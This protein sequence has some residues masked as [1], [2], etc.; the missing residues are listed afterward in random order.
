MLIQRYV[1]FQVQQV[2]TDPNSR[3][4]ILVVKSSDS[5]IVY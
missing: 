1:C 3:F 4:I 5:I 2:I